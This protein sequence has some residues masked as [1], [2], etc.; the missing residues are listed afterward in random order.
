MN[1]GSEDL[2]LL[3]LNFNI[4]DILRDLVPIV[5]FQEQEKHPWRSVTFSKLQAE[6][7]LLH[8]CFSRFLDFTNGTKSRKALHIHLINLQILQLPSN[9]YLYAGEAT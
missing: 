5:Q 1:G 3:L 2:L 8:G 4:C 6:E 9:I 7:T